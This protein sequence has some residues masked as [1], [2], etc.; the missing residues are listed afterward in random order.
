VGRELGRGRGRSE[1]RWREV[2]QKV[3][4]REGGGGGSG[5]RWRGGVPKG[6]VGRAYDVL[7]T[8]ILLC[9]DSETGPSL[10]ITR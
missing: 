4:K 9:E 5:G 6:G 2:A 8:S 3:E 1:G 10:S 7:L